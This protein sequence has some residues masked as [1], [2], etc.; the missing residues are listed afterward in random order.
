ML[1]GISP[2]AK[3]RKLTVPTTNNNNTTPSSCEKKGGL[4]V[5][6]TAPHFDTCMWEKKLSLNI[7]TLAKYCPRLVSI[8]SP[9]RRRPG[10]S[11]ETSLGRNVFYHSVTS[12][13]CSVPLCTNSHIYAS[14]RAG[15]VK[16]LRG[17]E[18]EEEE[19]GERG[20]EQSHR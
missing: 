8:I 9:K 3:C 16:I 14:C 11:N 4:L 20:G 7:S 5:D 2:S 17:E 1:V 12:A 18:E 10:S 13:A 15:R 19:K 6:E